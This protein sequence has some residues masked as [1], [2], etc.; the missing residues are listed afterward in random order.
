[1]AERLKKKII[2]LIDYTTIP[3]RTTFHSFTVSQL[4][5]KG[6]VP[7]WKIVLSYIY[8]HILIYINKY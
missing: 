1:M 3:V 7:L 8:I 6:G 5:F 4:N 2:F